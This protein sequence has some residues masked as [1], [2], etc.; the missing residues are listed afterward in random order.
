MTYVCVP[1]GPM[2]FSFSP[3]PSWHLVPRM[4]VIY[5]ADVDLA[6]EGASLA[7]IGLEGSQL[8]ILMAVNKSIEWWP[9][10]ECV[11]YYMLAKRM[12]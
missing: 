4:N 9:C 5:E 1:S 2:R 11:L 6:Y 3:M 8:P 12:R 7:Y 10:L